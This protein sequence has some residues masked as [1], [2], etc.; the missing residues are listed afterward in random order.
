LEEDIAAAVIELSDDDL[1]ELDCA[2]SKIRVQGAR[3]APA[4]QA[5]VGR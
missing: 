5:K 1:R 2:A 4:Q 3:Y